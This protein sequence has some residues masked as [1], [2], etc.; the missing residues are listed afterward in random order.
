M[1][2]IGSHVLSLSCDGYQTETREI[3]LGPGQQEDIHVTLLELFSFLLSAEPQTAEIELIFDDGRQLSCES[4]PCSISAT[5]GTGELVAVA[6][7][8][9]ELTQPFDLNDDLQLVLTLDQ[10]NEHLSLSF[11]SSDL[12]LTHASNLTVTNTS[13]SRTIEFSSQDEAFAG[14]VFL[15]IRRI[16]QSNDAE[17]T[18]GVRCLP[19]A[20]VAL[21]DGDEESTP[22]EVA[23]QRLD[24]DTHRL[25]IRPA[26]EDPALT[27]E[28][29]LR[30]VEE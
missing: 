27:I 6:D 25:T 12:E 18:I 24:V 2:G 9:H 8:Y 1:E 20:M 29:R 26:G 4:T 11:R 10:I 16:E 23:Q 15:D 13:A 3:E 22:F 14:R 5:Q 17:A 7:G 28:M 21:D 30:L 19:W